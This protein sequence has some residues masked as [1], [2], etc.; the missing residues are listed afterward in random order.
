MS[1]Y[2]FIAQSV[3]FESRLPFDFVILWVL[4][5]YYVASKRH[6]DAGED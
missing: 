5:F 3:V 1:P 2:T 6:Y 4:S